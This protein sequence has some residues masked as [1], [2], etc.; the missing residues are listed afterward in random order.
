M[1]STRRANAYSLAA[2][3]GPLMADRDVKSLSVIS[4]NTKDVPIQRNSLKR[5]DSPFM[6]I[7][8]GGP[9]VS[10]PVRRS[11]PD[12]VRGRDRRWPHAAGK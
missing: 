5:L 8:I 1:L 4:C 7:P 3:H 6:R 11:M 10:T 2:K 9:S 12:T